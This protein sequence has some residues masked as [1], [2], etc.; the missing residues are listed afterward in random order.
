MFEWTPVI[1]ECF[2]LERPWRK[3][4][5]AVRLGARLCSAAA[6]QT[7]NH[8]AQQD[9]LERV[10][11]RT[12][13]APSPDLFLSLF[14]DSGQI[15]DSQQVDTEFSPSVRKL[16]GGSRAGEPKKQSWSCLQS[17]KQVETRSA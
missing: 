8:G 9:A 7:R 16:T 10:D 14:R 2:I 12:G 11:P 1:S 4:R 5:F 17:T 13:G 6:E 3:W 15:R